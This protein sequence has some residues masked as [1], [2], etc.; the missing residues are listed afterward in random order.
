VFRT[1]TQIETAAS[2]LDWLNKGVLSV[3]RDA[4][5]EAFL[6]GLSGRMNTSLDSTRRSAPH[7]RPGGSRLSPAAPRVLAQVSSLASDGRGMP[8]SS[9]H[10][11]STLPTRTTTPPSGVT[12]PKIGPLATWWSELSIGFARI[13]CLVNDAG[14]L[15]GKPF[16]DYTLHDYDLITSVNVARFFHL[17]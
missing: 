14:V 7:L 3:S 17:T 5:P 4:N 6:R 12:S 13:G 10:A 1:S 15:T 11:P 2:D 9:P 8:L 16:T